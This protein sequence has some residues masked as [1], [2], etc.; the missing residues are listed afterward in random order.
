LWVGQAAERGLPREV[1]LTPIDKGPALTTDLEKRNA[2]Q[3]VVWQEARVH[4]HTHWR[5][6][7]AEREYNNAANKAQA[8]SACGQQGHKNRKIDV[9]RGPQRDLQHRQ[10]SGCYHYPWTPSY[11]PLDER[12]IR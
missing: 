9:V 11:V 8:C 10:A 7:Q 3:K 2:R 6:C 5:T 4:R 12:Q 1:A